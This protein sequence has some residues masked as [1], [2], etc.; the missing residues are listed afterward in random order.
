[1]SDTVQSVRWISTS[2]AEIPPV[3]V[4]R[5]PSTLVPSGVQYSTVASQSYLLSIQATQWPYIVFPYNI[6]SPTQPLSNSLSISH[7]LLQNS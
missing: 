7:R 6:Y 5:V 2:I 4:G 1:M 3:Q